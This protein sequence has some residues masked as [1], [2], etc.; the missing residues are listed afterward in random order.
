MGKAA[1]KGLKV[2][3][4]QLDKMFDELSED[5]IGDAPDSPDE[6]E[7]T[8]PDPVKPSAVAKNMKKKNKYAPVKNFN[9]YPVDSQFNY[10]DKK[11]L[12]ALA[13]AANK[14]KH[15]VYVLG[16]QNPVTTIAVQNV[17]MENRLCVYVGQSA[18]L[19]VRQSKHRDGS[20]DKKT[21]GKLPMFIGAVQVPN[22]EC[23]LA[24]ESRLKEY[25]ISDMKNDA[26]TELK[27][28]AGYAEL[29]KRVQQGYYS[30]GKKKTWY[31]PWVSADAPEAVQIER[32][33]S[34]AARF[35]RLNATLCFQRAANLRPKFKMADSY[36]LKKCL[37][38]GLRCVRRPVYL[39][40]QWI[41]LF[42][43]MYDPIVY[44][45]LV[46]D[47][48]KTMK[49]RVLLWAM[50]EPEDVAATKMF[51]RP[52]FDEKYSSVLNY[53]ELA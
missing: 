14:D 18:E 11:T 48:S 12:N 49:D 30:E 45:E 51:T 43:A 2:M 17:Q 37:A 35:A 27:R 40:D 50:Y 13:K 46:Q 23:A 5:E 28:W 21:A 1:K 4:N 7:P 25:E 52:W 47:R 10:Q 39:Q 34:A 33:Y 38:E 41:R 19:H 26:A 20:G 53:F 44:S 22:L 8:E 15:F 6:D 16:F 29:F 24:Y 9:M 42:R 36:Y 31:P 3:Q 32:V